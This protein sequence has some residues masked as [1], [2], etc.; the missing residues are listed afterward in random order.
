MF[1]DYLLSNEEKE[2][3]IVL[4]MGQKNETRQKAGIR[5]LVYFPSHRSRKKV[6]RKI[7]L[8]F[9]ETQK[10]EREI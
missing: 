5:C 8:S 4:R 2:G 6:Y 9:A 7:K 10:K 3:I 1:P